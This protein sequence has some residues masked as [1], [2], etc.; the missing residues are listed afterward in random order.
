[1]NTLISLTIL[2]TAKVSN[3]FKAVKLIAL[4]SILSHLMSNSKASHPLD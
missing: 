1:M 3:Q 4:Q 2:M